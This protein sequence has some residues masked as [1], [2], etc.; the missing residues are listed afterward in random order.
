MCKFDGFSHKEIAEILGISVSTV[1]KHLV[2]G[3]RLCRAHLLQD[4]DGGEQ[5]EHRRARR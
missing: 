5:M 1:E 4:R 2:K 3:L